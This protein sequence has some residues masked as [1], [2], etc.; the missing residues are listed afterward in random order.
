MSDGKAKGAALLAVRGV[1]KTYVT[2][3]E[4]LSVLRDVNL[5]LSESEVLA[6]VG[7]SGVGKST[8]LHIL[9]ALDRPDG[10]TVSVAGEDVFSLDDARLA[11]F[12]NATFGFVFQFHHLLG[13][14]TAL[15]NVMMPCL[16]AGMPEGE[17]MK[18]AA[19]VLGEDVGLRERFEHRPRELSGGEQQRVAVAR[20]LVMEPRVV[21][22]DEPS[23]NL[24]PEHGEAL[25]NLL[26]ELRDTRGQS[27]VL[28]T[29]STELAARADRVLK[30]FDGMVEEVKI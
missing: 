10:G 19:R 11:Q 16:I 12:R 15:E 5:D 2:G 9:G 27:F 23:G 26:F 14:F 8:L 28:V 24:D 7:P 6:I 18:R 13:E 4:V 21:F 25:H 22:A 1:S 30:L 20:A 29:H 3:P 17:A